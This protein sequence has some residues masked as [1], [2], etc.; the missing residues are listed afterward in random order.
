MACF[1]NTSGVLMCDVCMDGGGRGAVVISILCGRCSALLAL[2]SPGAGLVAYRSPFRIQG[3]LD[4]A[5]VILAR[6]PLQSTG[7]SS[8]DLLYIVRYF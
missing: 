3:F 2:R 4:I 5:Q 8:Q 1:F 6:V 7:H